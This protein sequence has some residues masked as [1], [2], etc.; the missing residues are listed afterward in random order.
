MAKNQQQ[1]NKRAERE[2]K[3]NQHQSEHHKL[4][5]TKSDFIRLT[6]RILL[7]A[8]ALCG[9]V[10]GMLASFSR[11]HAAL[12]VLVLTIALVLTDVEIYWVHELGHYSE[13]SPLFLIWMGAVILFL[14]FG[15]VY[16][17]F[18]E[19]QSPIPTFQRVAPKALPGATISFGATFLGEHPFTIRGR[20]PPFHVYE[21][22]G[23]VFCDVN[24]YS[25]GS[26]EIIEIKHNVIKSV[27]HG[28]DSNSNDKGMEIVNEDWQPVFQMYYETPTHLRIQGI[29]VA[30]PMVFLARGNDLRFFAF[31]SPDLPSAIANFKLNRLFKYPSSVF[32]GVPN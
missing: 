10:A 29:I 23:R 24:T 17:A 7:A 4:P 30:M 19:K 9:V 3:R 22:N 14:M 21:E 26:E 5:A 20:E 1:H 28:W 13:L 6:T 15:S 2:A 8:F 16:S 18:M 32:P 12:W 27:P 11:P 31:T 25:V